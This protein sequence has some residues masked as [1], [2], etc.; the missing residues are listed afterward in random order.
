MPAVDLVVF[1][2]ETQRLD[3]ERAKL[4]RDVVIRF[5]SPAGVAPREHSFLPDPH[6][7]ATLK[8][9]RLGL[10]EIP[11]VNSDAVLEAISGILQD[12][13]GAISTFSY[14][15]NPITAPTEQ[16]VLDEFS[17]ECDLVISAFGH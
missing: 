17:R 13:Y 6:I 16:S 15:K 7:L 8:G 11:F 3:S 5:L 2:N 9:A 10:L 1:V 12:R 14:Q 4:R